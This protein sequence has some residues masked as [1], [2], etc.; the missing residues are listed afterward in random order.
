MFFWCLPL[1]LAL[2][3]ASVW[4]ALRLSGRPLAGVVIPA[5]VFLPHFIVM[6]I[7]S[8]RQRKIRIIWR[9]SGGRVCIHCGHNLAGLADIGVCPECGH[10]FDTHKDRG[11]WS[12]VPGFSRVEWD[13]PSV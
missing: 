3:V 12:S 7:L 10:T 13:R 11:K 6:W 9:E 1:S 4:V 5:I 2:A 8:R